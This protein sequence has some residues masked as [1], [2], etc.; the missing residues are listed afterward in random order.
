MQSPLME[1]R[2]KH[3]LTLVDFY[4]FFNIGS[5]CCRAT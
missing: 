1:L 4:L 5:G 2:E 3:D